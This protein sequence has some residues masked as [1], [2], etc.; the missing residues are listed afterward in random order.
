MS[1]DLATLRDGKKLMWDGCVYEAREDATRA[2]QS[3]Q[4]AGFETLLAEDGG[5]FLVYT[6]KVVQ[7]VV[8]T[9]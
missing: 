7:E 6:R 3:Y 8:V 5:K 1:P 2:L 4:A 9:Q